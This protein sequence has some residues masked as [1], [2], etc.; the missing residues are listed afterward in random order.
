MMMMINI[1]IAVLIGLIS[2]PGEL[3]SVADCCLFPLHNMRAHYFCQTS[4][5]N[6]TISL[7]S[8]CL[9]KMRLLLSFLQLATFNND[10]QTR[11]QA[12]CELGP[13]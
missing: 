5:A 8:R 12:L 11:C 1:S 4:T 2:L 6:V 3:I 9:F 7:A 10:C 13:L